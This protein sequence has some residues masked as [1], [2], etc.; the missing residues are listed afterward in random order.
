V[1]FVQLLP[2]NVAHKRWALLT[3]WQ[4][5]T[6]MMVQLNTTKGFDEMENYKEMYCALFN[7]VSKAI[8]ALQEAQRKVEEMYISADRSKD[9]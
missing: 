3:M 1:G 5:V 4:N 7:E 9:N 8:E 2:Q 6:I